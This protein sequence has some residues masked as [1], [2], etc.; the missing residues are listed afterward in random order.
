V[1]RTTIA[2]ACGNWSVVSQFARFWSLFYAVLD[3]GQ[4]LLAIQAGRRTSALHAAGHVLGLRHNDDRT[5]IVQRGI[6][7]IVAIV[8]VG[9]LLP[10]VAA[11]NHAAP[12]GLSVTGVTHNQVALNWNDY[13]RFAPRAYRVS[14][15]N[16]SGSLI[17]IGLT[18][19]T[20]SD[21]VWTGLSEST[22]YRFAVR[23]V[24]AGGHLSRPSAQATATT[25][26]APA[27]PQP[28]TVD[29][30]Q[31]PNG[32]TA[33]TGAVTL[34]ANATGAAKV[35]FWA[36]GAKLSEDATA[37]YTAT[38][39]AVAGRHQVAAVANDGQGQDGVWDGHR[40]VDT[41]SVTVEPATPAPSP[42]GHPIPVLEETLPAAGMPG[43][44]HGVFS[45]WDTNHT[46]VY[47]SGATNGDKHGTIRWEPGGHYGAGQKTYMLLGHRVIE[48]SPGR[49]QEG[50]TQPADAPYGWTPLAFPGGP[51]TGVAPFSV[52]WFKGSGRGFEVV[53]EPND[54][55]AGTG[56]YH[57]RLFTDAEM[58]AR[59][60][61]WIWLWVEIVWGRGDD[62]APRQ[63]SLRV[64]V[65]G[66]DSPRINVS[67]IKTH[68]FGEGMVTFWE[69]TY[70][71]GG[72]S[73]RSVVEHAGPRF[74]RTPQ[75]AYEDNP[76]L[77]S[78]WT[79]DSGR[80]SWQAK[81]DVDGNVPVPPSLR[82]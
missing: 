60:G 81:S 7:L 9:L 65:A 54:F 40:V 13:T 76:R 41:H 18:G 11:A 51:P 74:G 3:A 82:W 30:T 17:D 50:H 37:P 22:T 48:G 77:Y 53:V 52:D 28:L 12:T 57:F 42:S 38:W 1:V 45:V 23:A 43:I 25:R 2:D 46:E 58:E 44:V 56:T 70:W 73:Q 21:Y 34:E 29:L 75:E 20:S 10:A 31:P 4:N 78:A 33:G 59:R 49:M 67:G 72:N 8:L 79:G 71:F 26:A 61:Q 55:P 63:G 6:N 64:W 69:A 19:S 35:E 80:G 14:R 47:P 24:A 27:P 16:A 32:A 36:D 62:S 5:S 39:N 66:E 15:Y 68:W